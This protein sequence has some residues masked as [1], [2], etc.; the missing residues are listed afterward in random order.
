MNRLKTILYIATSQDGFI[1][2]KDGGVGWLDPYNNIEGEDCGYH[3]F[4]ESIDGIIMGS[5]SYEQI[6]GFGEWIWPGKPSFVFT[7]KELKAERPEVVLVHEDV[8]TFMSQL[9]SKE[10]HQN[11]WLLGGV[12]LIKSF[13]A[14]GLIDECII[15]IIPTVLGEGIP[16]SLPYEDFEL[17]QTKE[18]KEGIK[19]KIY[20][21][22]K[23]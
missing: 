19:Q 20:E 15:T 2:D 11:L 18:C 7:A 9:G 14:L 17:M 21:R 5:R 12:E 10:Q 8:T 13:A 3:G 22:K 1:A 23:T 6:L 16:L 4:Y